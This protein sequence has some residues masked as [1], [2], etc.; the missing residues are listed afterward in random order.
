[1]IQDLVSHVDW[2]CCWFLSLH[3][4][5]SSGSSGFPP[6][7][8]YQ[9]SKF[10]LNLVK[11]DR[12]SHPT[13]CPL[14]ISSYFFFWVCVCVYCHPCRLCHVW[15]QSLYTLSSRGM[16]G[17]LLYHP[18]INLVPPPPK[19]CSILMIPSIGRQCSVAPPPL[20]ALLAM[21]VSPPCYPENH[22]VP[23]SFFLPHPP[24][25]W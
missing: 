5:V 17:F 18:E 25:P 10:Q 22:A 15:D 21:T 14:L 1:M 23:P 9:H 2:L 12:K 11:V 16:G 4:G 13:D 6:L 7:A 24:P 20:C 19:L 8:K 3:Q